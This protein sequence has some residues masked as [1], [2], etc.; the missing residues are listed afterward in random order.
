MFICGQIIGDRLATGRF[1]RRV[2]SAHAAG[3]VGGLT[4]ITA[5]MPGSG[6]S[7]TV[8]YRFSAAAVTNVNTAG[9]DGRCAG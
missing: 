6:P 5:P 8:I 1:C 3:G 7:A 2:R 9:G 4:F